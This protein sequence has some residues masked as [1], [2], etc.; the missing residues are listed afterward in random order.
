MSVPSVSSSIGAVFAGFVFHGYFIEPSAGEAYWHG[1]IAFR[2]HSMHAMHEVPSG[3]KSS[4]SA[5]MSLGSSGAYVFYIR[6]PEAPRKSAATYRPIYSFSLN[7]WYFDELYNSSFVRPA[8]ALGR[9][10]WH[11]GDEKTINRSGP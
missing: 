5:A 6:A 7:K 3:V 11:R 2:E 8:F 10:F 1:A 4:A 9:F